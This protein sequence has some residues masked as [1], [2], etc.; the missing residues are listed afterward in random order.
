MKE[1]PNKIWKYQKFVLSLSY[2]QNTQAMR[3]A[4]QLHDTE[5]EEILG[6]VIV[7]S[8]IT[9]N[10]EDEVFEGWEDFNKLEEHELDHENVDDFVE[11]FNE[12]YKT[13]IERLYIEFIQPSADDEFKHTK[14]MFGNEP[15][16]D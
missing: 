16:Q 9:K 1:K 7:T 12:N 11:W 3:K 2:N 10:T 6:S 8:K 15:E 14:R 5:T 13:Q 4:Y